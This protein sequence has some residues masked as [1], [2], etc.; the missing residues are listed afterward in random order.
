MT[1]RADVPAA[2]RPDIDIAWYGV[3]LVLYIVAG[4]FMK[5]AVLNWIVGPLFPLV[6][7][8]FVPRLLR[9][10]KRAEPAE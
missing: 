3:A 2:G 5:S 4:Y 8:Y 6:V 9:R 1:D 7:L 10:Q